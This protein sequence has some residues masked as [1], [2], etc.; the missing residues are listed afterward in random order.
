MVWMH[1][2]GIAQ[3]CR[4]FSMKPL[5]VASHTQVAIEG[6]LCRTGAKKVEKEKSNPLAMEGWLCELLESAGVPEVSQKAR[7][8]TSQSARSSQVPVLNGAWKVSWKAQV[9]RAKD[10]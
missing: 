9:Q 7:E 8:K 3:L 6:N 2:P 1:R 4:W 10:S 5:R